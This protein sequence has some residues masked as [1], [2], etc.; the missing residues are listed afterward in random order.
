MVGVRS[1]KHAHFFS[2]QRDIIIILYYPHFVLFKYEY[3][4]IYNIYIYIYIPF[5][6]HLFPSHYLWFL[7]G[8]PRFIL[9]HKRQADKLRKLLRTNGIEVDDRDRSW[10]LGLQKTGGWW[11]EL[12][13]K[14]NGTWKHPPQ[15]N[16]VLHFDMIFKMELEGTHD[17]WVFPSPQKKTTETVSVLETLSQPCGWFRCVPLSRRW[18]FNTFRSHIKGGN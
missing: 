5:A 3:T 12:L 17:T 7:F 13:P 11:N 1:P 10:F 18:L 9:S 16:M 2:K 6:H 14:K 8:K 4:Y 15:K